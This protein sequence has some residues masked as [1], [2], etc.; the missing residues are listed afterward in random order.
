MIGLINNSYLEFLSINYGQDAV[1]KILD[2]AGLPPDTLNT[3]FVSSCPY[4]DDILLNG[5]V[6]KR[7]R[8]LAAR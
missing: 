5:Y 3:G 1:E 7:G 8:G 4:A 6:H 2:V